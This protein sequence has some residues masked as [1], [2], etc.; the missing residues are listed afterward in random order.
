MTLNETYSFLGQ[1]RRK[2]YAMQCKILQRDELQASLLP[3]AIAY[4][5]DRV[6][7]SPEDR[8]SEI[9][10]KIV[11]LDQV[12]EQMRVRRSEAVK[13]VC[14]ALDQ[15]PDDRERL[16]LTH[17]YVTGHTMERTAEVVGYTVQHVYRLRDRG[18]RHLSALI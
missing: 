7:T 8:Q 4:D 10:S 12:I 14:E 9:M 16:I 15:L 5:S 1:V 2:D 13:R 3:K 11:E 17:Y 6:Q 18:V